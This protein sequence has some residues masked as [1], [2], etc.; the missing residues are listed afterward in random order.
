MNLKGLYIF[1]L[2]SMQ[3]GRNM[4]HTYNLF[5]NKSLSSVFKSIVSHLC[6]KYLTTC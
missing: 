1:H 2:V 4:N 3:Y 6:S 5:V